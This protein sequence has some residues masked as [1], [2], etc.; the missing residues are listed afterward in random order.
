MASSDDSETAQGAMRLT[1]PFTQSWE[2]LTAKRWARTAVATSMKPGRHADLGRAL[3]A[4][5]VVLSNTHGAIAYPRVRPP[6]LLS[7]IPTSLSLDL[8]RFWPFWTL[9]LDTRLEDLCHTWRSNGTS[10]IPTFLR[11]LSTLRRRTTQPSP[12]DMADRY[13]RLYMCVTQDRFGQLDALQPVTID[14]R[15]RL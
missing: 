3:Y 7:L 9:Y 1:N 4:R 14:S 12:P 6:A 2:S 5:R 13:R 11:R 10:E 8:R 15:P